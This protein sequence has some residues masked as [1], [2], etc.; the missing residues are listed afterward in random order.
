MRNMFTDGLA[1]K[2]A[3]VDSH[4]AN[5]EAD[6]DPHQYYADQQEVTK[7]YIFVY[8]PDSDADRVGLYG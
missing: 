6:G 8:L 7:Q 3:S 5:A 1:D 4:T 2:G